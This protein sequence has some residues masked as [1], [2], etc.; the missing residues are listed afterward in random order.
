VDYCL[1]EAKIQSADLDYIVFYEKPL[2]KFDRLL[3]TYLAFAPRGL[4]SFLMAMPLW[5]RT[6]MHLPREI[7]KA[8]DGHFQ[9][10]IVFTRH[11]ESHAASAF[12]SSPF[13]EAAILTMD[14]VG[15]WDTASIGIGRGNRVH[16]LKTLQFPH[17][18]GLLYTRVHL[19]Y[20]LPRQLWRIQTDGPGAVW[21]TKY[22]D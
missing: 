15:E 17:S 22:V 16:F 20:R 21:R 12:F 9:G 7:R 8:F 6:K 19:F 11:H 1:R 18:L 4:R 10:N 2:L 13:D 3:E 14:G 5:L